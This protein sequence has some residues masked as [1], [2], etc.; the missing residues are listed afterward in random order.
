[1][2]NVR[3]SLNRRMKMAE[4]SQQQKELHFP[5]IDPVFLWHRKT[6]DGYITIPRT[7]P[8]AMQAVDMQ[9]TKGQ[10]A[11]HTLFSLWARSPD[12]SVIIVENPATFAAEAGFTGERAVDTW[13]KRMKIL[14]ELWMIQTKPGASGEFHYVILMNPNVSLEW[15]WT[16]GKV[17]E[18]LYGRFIDRVMEIGAFS[19]IDAVR[20]FWKLQRAAN[21]AA[22]QAAA[23]AAASQSAPSSPAELEVSQKPAP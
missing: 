19:E 16:H 18:G 6:N 1:M 23:A 2:A 7:L 17:Q 11:G 9:S 22:V 13:R 3:Q 15:M 4:R 21:E 20:E 5:H 14:R 12:N 10:P 8:I